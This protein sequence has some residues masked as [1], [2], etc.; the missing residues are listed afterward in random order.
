MT[1]SPELQRHQ[2]PQ[3]QPKKK[4]IAENNMFMT[5]LV[6][7]MTIDIG[8]NF[9]SFDTAK[10]YGTWKNKRSQ[11][12]KTHLKSFRLKASS[13]IYVKETLR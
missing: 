4:W 7:S 1:T 10:E 8:E 5:W 2:K 3:H 13:I 6:N 11:I 9:L 12:R